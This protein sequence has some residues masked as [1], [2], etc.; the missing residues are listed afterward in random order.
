VIFFGQSG[1][2]GTLI[3]ERKEMNGGNVKVKKKKKEHRSQARNEKE[4]KK[5]KCVIVL[6]LICFYLGIYFFLNRP[7]PTRM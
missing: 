7:K 5:R 6:Y 4:R 2:R 3:V 1:V